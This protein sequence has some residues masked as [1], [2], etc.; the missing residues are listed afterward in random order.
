MMN[1]GCDGSIPNVSFVDV[2][3][4][5]QTNLA[6]LLLIREHCVMLVLFVDVLD[7]AW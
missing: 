1:D 5:P 2:N 3:L 4:V 7:D 6:I